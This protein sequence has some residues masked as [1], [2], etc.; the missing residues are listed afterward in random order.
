[1]GGQKLP[2][3]VS[4]AV[5]GRKMQRR[6]PLIRYARAKIGPTPSLWWS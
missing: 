6:R 4:G 2:I 1:M 3:R 5:G